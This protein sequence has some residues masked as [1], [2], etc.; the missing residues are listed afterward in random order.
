M[1]NTHITVYPADDLLD[2]QIDRAFTYHPPVRDQADRYQLLREAARHFAEAIADY[3]PPSA[4]RTLAVRDV[5]RACMW[6]NAAIARNE[7]DPR[8]LNPNPED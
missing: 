5:E 6:A 2:T 1:R 3:C 8:H 7:L 4:E